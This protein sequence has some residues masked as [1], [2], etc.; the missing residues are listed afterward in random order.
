MTEKR[1]FY[2]ELTEIAESRIKELMRHAEKMEDH[3][4]GL[5]NAGKY[6]RDC[7]FTVYVAW[8][9]VTDGWHSDDDLERLKLLTDGS[10]WV[11]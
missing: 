9:D 3:G 8:C 7:A 6:F 5:P 11:N 10:S 4:C 2:Q 1:C